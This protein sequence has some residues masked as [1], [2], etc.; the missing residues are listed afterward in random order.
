MYNYDYGL[1]LKLFGICLKYIP[2]T[3]FIAFMTLITGLIFGTLLAMA[4]MSKS[5]PLSM[6]SRIYILLMR[7]IPSVLF[8]L[9]TYN[10]LIR[11]FDALSREYHWSV[12]SSIIPKPLIAIVALSF[13]ASAVLAETIR[14]AFLS[15]H[16]G[17]YEAAYSVGMTKRTA[18]WRII[19]PQTLPVAIPIIGSNFIIFIKA[20]ALVNM[21]GIIDILNSVIIHVSAS[22]KY[23]EAYITAAL[24]YWLIT[25]I[26]E[27]GVKLLSLNASRRLGMEGK[28]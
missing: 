13:N 4:R 26:I 12:N 11:G 21:L 8:L 18:L 15:V 27:K 24:I 28:V 20:T 22:Y 16:P 7:G 9:I 3:L 23:L 2:I 5:K 10:L 1:M 17:Q 14:T 19:L 25:I 6:I